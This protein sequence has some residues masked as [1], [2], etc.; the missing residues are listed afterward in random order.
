[1]PFEFIQYSKPK[2]NYARITIS[3]PEVMNALNLQVR[4][5]IIEALDIAEKDDS[6]RAVVLTGAGEK[7]FSAGAD[8]NM[9]LTM[10]PYSAKEYLKTSKGASNK[11]ES[12]PKPV[13]AAVNGY[14]IGGGLELA[15]SCDIIIA[16]ENAKFGQGEINVGAIP[17]VGGTQRLPR[18]VGIKKAKEMIYTGDLIDSSEALRL[19]LVNRVVPLQDLSRVVEELVDKISSKSPMI[20]RL[21]KDA[22][23]HS[24]AGLAEGLDYESALFAFCFST[25]DQKEGARAFLEKRKPVFKGN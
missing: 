22:L 14:A 10:T 7:A 5:E 19:G 24:V 1:M 16:S 25:S 12:F 15:M 17:G 11:L 13:I 20:L 23:N 18:L 8:I 4:K 2:E 6:V 3:R 21:A 9:F